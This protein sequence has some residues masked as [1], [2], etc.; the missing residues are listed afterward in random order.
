MKDVERLC[1]LPVRLGELPGS[2]DNAGLDE[3]R[4][5]LLFG[6]GQVVPE[7]LHGFNGLLQFLFAHRGPPLG[8]NS[9]SFSIHPNVNHFE[10]SGRFGLIMAMVMNMA[11]VM[12]LV[13][14]AAIPPPPPKK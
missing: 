6:G 14:E 4:Q 2:R 12:P 3:E 10:R 5:G 8:T 1:T 7:V 9:G 11:T 13:E